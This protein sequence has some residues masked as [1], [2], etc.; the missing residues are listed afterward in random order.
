MRIRYTG[1][2]MAQRLLAFALAFVIVG[3]PLAS[4]VCEAV[5]AEHV[6]HS[7]AS[8]MPASH[9]HHAGEAV[10]QPLHHHH[11]DTAAAPATQSAGFMPPPH[12]CGYLEAIVTDSRGA[13]RAPIVKAVMT[14][15]CVTPVLG[16]VLAASELDSRHGPPIPIRSTSPLRI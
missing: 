14:T 5:C 7:I 2:Q 6:A 16:H 11:A 8:T 4:D 15:A 13:T 3:G 10:S 12:R 1:E 9:H